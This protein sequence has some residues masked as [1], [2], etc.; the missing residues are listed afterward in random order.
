MIMLW[1]MLRGGLTSKEAFERKRDEWIAS[2][3]G[4]RGSMKGAALLSSYAFGVQTQD[5]AREGLRLFP[6]IK[7][8]TASC[9]R[10]GNLAAA[11][12]WLYVLAG[13]PRQALAPLRSVVN[14]CIAL[15]SPRMHVRS[16]WFLGQALEATGDVPG[17]CAAYAQVVGR[18]GNA[19]PPSLTATR[20][21]ERARALRCA[22][23]SAAPEG[24]KA[25]SARKAT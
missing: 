3:R 23:S 14:S 9:E 5:E 20:A 19:S 10:D 6:E 12:G 1:A 7:P 15:E 16:G 21:R 22:D 11:L 17:A 18:W 2:Q 8:L 24:P 25:A 4:T 13:Q